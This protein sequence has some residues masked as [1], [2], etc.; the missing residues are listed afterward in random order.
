MDYQICERN[1][2][3]LPLPVLKLPC[4]NRDH[5][6]RYFCFV[7]VLVINNKYNYK[8]A[9]KYLNPILQTKYLQYSIILELALISQGRVEHLM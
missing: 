5:T 6:T 4:C 9:S 2:I 1:N 3:I 8:D 7:K